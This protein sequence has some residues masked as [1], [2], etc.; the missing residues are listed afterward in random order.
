MI[1][2]RYLCR[3]YFFSL[4]C[5]DALFRLTRM[6]SMSVIEIESYNANGSTRMW[7][8]AWLVAAVVAQRGV[9]WCQ[10]FPYWRT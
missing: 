7:I 10:K 1:C 6:N 8:A 4:K 2:I 3:D 9:V 5:S